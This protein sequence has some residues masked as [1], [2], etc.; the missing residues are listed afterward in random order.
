[1]CDLI[2]ELAAPLVGAIGVIVTAVVAIQSIRKAAEE[3]RITTTH[4][5]MAICLVDTI[6]IFDRVINLLNDVVN[7]VTY[8]DISK[9]ID[10]E[11]AHSRYWREI[12]EL[13]SKF[14][15][16]YA[17][18]KLFLP[19]DIYSDVQVI[20]KKLN[21]ARE[22]ARKP[23]DNNLRNLIAQVGKNYDALVDKCRS[24][25]GPHRLENIK[26]DKGFSLGSN[27]R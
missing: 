13:S 17:R 12:G 1:M 16:I 2:S 19:K 20:I 21:D 15:N 11:S 18:Q 7:N 8:H 25:L 14:K 5:E 24:Y 9:D 27:E 4:R 10:I 23:A 26:G 6:E 3:S 22:L